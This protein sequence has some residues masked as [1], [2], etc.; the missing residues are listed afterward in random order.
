VYI[1]E[2]ERQVRIYIKKNTG[3][4]KLPLL[5]GQT[6]RVVGILQKTSGAYRLL[7]RE[8]KDITITASPRVTQSKEKQVFAIPANGPGIREYGTATFVAA[9]V[10]VGGLMLRSYRKRKVYAFKETTDTNLL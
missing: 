1:E 9:I 10:I 2:G 8:E 3:I 7:P 5:A 6:V 4:S